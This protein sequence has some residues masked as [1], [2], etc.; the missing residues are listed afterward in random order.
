MKT[1]GF[2]VPCYNEESTLVETNFQLNQYINDLINQSLISNKSFIAYVDDGSTDKTYELI[3][4]FN[5]SD[6]N[7]RLI[8]LSKNFGHQNAI[9]AG[10]I[11][12]HT[13]ADALITLDA[14]L[15]DDIS[16]I[17]E[18]ILKF[19]Q[20]NQIVYGVRKNR[21]SD[22]FIKKTTAIYFYKLMKI[23]GVNIIY[24]HADFR[25][26]SQ[27]VIME[28]LKYEE[29]NLFLRGIFPALGFST[30]IVYYDRKDRFAGKTKY[31][32]FKMLSFAWEGIT[33]FSIQ[34][35]RIITFIGV[36]IF[37]ISLLLSSYVI[38]GYFNH[39]VVPGW[40]SIALPIYFIG[41]IQLLSIGIV[42]EYIGK[43]YKEVKR[44]PR[45]IIEKIV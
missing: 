5:L 17:K 4:N 39:N 6:K 32:F 37:L 30:S 18:M 31:P 14:D 2:V 19:I 27:R 38:I 42:G 20:G 36:I 7:I 25:L 24:N 13:E 3:S 9:L 22:T 33:S 43:I 10:L 29:A 34:P 16:V 35:L 12:F 45:F 28:L 15:Q 8:K 21:T 1:I 41:G 40:A 23:M 26:S 11:S 44:R